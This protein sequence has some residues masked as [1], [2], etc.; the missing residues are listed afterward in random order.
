MW[1]TPSW[2]KLIPTLLVPLLVSCAA[3]PRKPANV[4]GPSRPGKDLLAE[5]REVALF[6]S[7][8]GFDSASCVGYLRELYRRIDG[9]NSNQYDLEQTLETFPA[10]S[11]EL[12]KIRLALHHKLPEVSRECAVEMKAAFRAIRA[13][14][15]YLGEKYYRVKP[16][17]ASELDF[18]KQ[19]IP[20]KDRQGYPP[21]FVAPG[22]EQGDFQF[23]SGDILITRGVSFL[24][25]MIARLSDNDSQ[26]SHVVLVH[27]DKTIESYF[28]VGVGLYD[29]DFALKNENARI[30][31]LRAKDAALATRA[32]SMM[33]ELAKKRIDE[34]KP[35]PYDYKMDFKDRSALS[36]AEVGQY[37]YDLA[38]GGS[39]LIPQYPSS[40]TLNSPDFLNRIGQKQG[41][42][43]AP[44]DLE[45]DP[46]F[47]LVLEWRDY[48]L[49]RDSRYKDAILSQMYVWME[50]Y[51]YK[52]RGDAKSWFAENVVWR[53]RR[54]FL[55]PLVSTL[56]GVPDFSPEL[57]RKAFGTMA[58]LNQVG[59][60]LLQELIRIDGV[61][62]KNHGWPLTNRELE[63][64]LENI[65]ATDLLQYRRG[66]KS[67]IHSI[68]RPDKS[69]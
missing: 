40:V 53:S 63:N 27:A 31:V 22:Y 45:I 29:L 1:K 41:E 43:F 5:A 68:F 11:Q 30:I 25:A 65:R 13:T 8:S 64:L 21:F 69:R 18:Q 62:E 47:E 2:R 20:V 49:V 24:S 56:V 51:G 50:K 60:V 44:G 10:L 6:V 54:T 48:R 9:G 32:G 19:P 26:F 57:P 4:A 52:L 46:R 23:K 12:W 28:G 42:L 36:C 66:Q 61:Y 3:L 15:D 7:G 34:G 16:L 14:E 17:Q 35:I 58:L 59:E 38:S 67:L 55:W 39:V 33:Y 37:S